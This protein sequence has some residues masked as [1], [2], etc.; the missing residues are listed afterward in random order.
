RA[1][2]R[3]GVRALADGVE[4]RRSRL[5]DLREHLLGSLQR[6][7]VD[8]SR[9]EPHLVRG[10][11]HT[12]ADLPPQRELLQSTSQHWSDEDLPVA[13]EDRRDSEVARAYA[14]PGE[15]KE[16]LNGVGERPEAV[17]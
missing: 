12:L 9:D 17:K 7:K 3:F 10:D 15:L 1:R 8:H 11:E 13:L 2:R 6:I 5:F 16:F 4:Y 14:E